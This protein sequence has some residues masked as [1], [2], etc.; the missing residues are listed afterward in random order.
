LSMFFGNIVELLTITGL[1]KA[2]KQTESFA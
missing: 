2:L 1:I